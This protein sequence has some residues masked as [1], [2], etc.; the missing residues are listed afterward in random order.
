M[1]WGTQQELGRSQE[2]T[3]Q[4]STDGRKAVE[5][6]EHRAGPGEG[7]LS[8]STVNDLLD[9]RQVSRRVSS[10]NS[11]YYCFDHKVCPG[12]EI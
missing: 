2:S 3:L 11:F 1:V 8:H 12:K 7:V 9:L 5:L 6:S 4:I 10:R